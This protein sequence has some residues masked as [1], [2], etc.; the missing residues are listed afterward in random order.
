MA[1]HF[2]YCTPEGK[3]LAHFEDEQTVLEWFRR[4]WL[5]LAGADDP[6]EQAAEEVSR[7][8]GFYVYGFSWLFRRIVEHGS[9][10]PETDDQLKPYLE[11]YIYSEGSIL[12][13]PHLVTVETDDDVASLIYYIFDD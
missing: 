13:E 7:L 2:V 11:E 6:D 10:R 1:V 9:P 5:L 4:H 3:E 8:L 12:V